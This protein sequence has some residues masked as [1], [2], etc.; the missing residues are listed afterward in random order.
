MLPDSPK[1]PSSKESLQYIAFLYKI[2]SIIPSPHYHYNFKLGIPVKTGDVQN[3][4]MQSV[5]RLML[6]PIFIYF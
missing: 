4:V 5:A 6:L 3:Y 2:D 1:D